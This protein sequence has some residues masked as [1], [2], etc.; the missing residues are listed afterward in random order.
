MKSPINAVKHYVQFTQF[1]VASAAVQELLLVDSAVLQSVNT[2]P[3]VREGAVVKAIFVELWLLT[4]SSTVGSFVVIVEKAVA[5]Q[6]IPILS[7]MTG[8]HT[9]ENK[10]NILFTSQ[11]I[12]AGE[13]QGSPT[14]VLRQW[15]KIPKGKQRMGLNDQIRISIAAIGADALQGCSFATYKEYT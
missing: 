7:D 1:T 5:Q 9:Y 15:I 13:P 12:L 2:A 3:E 10:K 11:G 14:P 6:S 4:D 8:L